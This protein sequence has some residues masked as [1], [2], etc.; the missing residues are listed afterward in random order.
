MKNLSVFLIGCVF[1]LGLC[2]SGLMVPA[3]VLAFLDL[4]GGVGGAGSCQTPT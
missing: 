3:K 4:F 2:V 1:S